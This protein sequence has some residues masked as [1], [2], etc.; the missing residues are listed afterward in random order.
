[1]QAQPARCT[2]RT[3]VDLE[4]VSSQATYKV[5]YAPTGLKGDLRYGPNHSLHSTAYCLHT[6]QVVQALSRLPDTCVLVKLHYKDKIANPVEG[7]IQQQANSNIRGLKQMGFAGVL[8]WA[9]IVVLDLPTTT[10]IEAMA[11]AKRV[12][13]L[14]PDIFKLTTDGEALLKKTVAWVDMTPG[15][16]EA[17]CHTVIQAL[18]T[19]AP[20]PVENAFLA[21][22]ASLNFQ[23]ERLW[24]ILVDESRVSNVGS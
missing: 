21:A 10:L 2:N 5:L 16:E 22:Y 14:H 1:M 17:L 13:Y 11:E 12:V 24:E 20:D 19:P 9:D 8:P 3:S 23:P 6:I 7:W 4:V 18:R 15:W